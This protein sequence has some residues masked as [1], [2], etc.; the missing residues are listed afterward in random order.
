ME[1]QMRRGFSVLFAT[2]LA[3]CIPA[4][5][6]AGG[7]DL[8]FTARAEAG[9]DPATREFLALLPD[10]WR[11]KLNAIVNDTMNRVD[12][13][14]ANYVQQVDKLI[15]DQAIDIQ[16]HVVATERSVVDDI[17][18]RFPWAAPGGS[19]EK[20]QNQFALDNNRRNDQSKPIFVKTLYADHATAA[21][22]AA[23]QAGGVVV[24]MTQAKT[25]MADAS[26]KWIIWNRIENLHC[27][28]T[29]DCATS[30]RDQLSV[31]MRDSDARDLRSAQ[32]Q[33]LLDE[34][35]P[36]TQSAWW[37]GKKMNFDQLE[38]YLTQLYF[39]ENAIGGAKA[40]RESL[41]ISKLMEAQGYAKDGQDQ[42]NASIATVKSR[43]V[44]RFGPF[45]GRIQI[46]CT[47]LYPSA[48]QGVARAARL[49]NA[50]S[51]DLK[52]A[53]TLSGYVEQDSNTLLKDVNGLLP[54]TLDANHF[55]STI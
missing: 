4:K 6:I 19:L 8:S 46:P 10:V 16:C 37:S 40:V 29:K 55:C 32:A 17:V 3:C 35:K 43:M 5:L 26:S 36:P 25:L 49:F 48:D 34:D 30:Y 14:F 2:V 50:A 9:L 12:K 27:Q 13:S 38:A 39:V 31:L 47:S 51:A 21:S 45:N 42:L 7:L 28:T 18:S 53:I 23:C 22:I 52:E 41:A 44:L 11:P 24:A 15:S 33:K 20:L 54:R 1:L